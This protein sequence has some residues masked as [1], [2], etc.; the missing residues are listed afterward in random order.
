MSE[1]WSFP[2]RT[3]LA[4]ALV[5]V[6]ITPLVAWFGTIAVLRGPTKSRQTF[7]E[8]ETRQVIQEAHQQLQARRLE[9]D[10]PAFQAELK[11]LLD[12]AGFSVALFD[13]GGVLIHGSRALAMGGPKGSVYQ[14]TAHYGRRQ[15]TA[16]VYDAEEKVTGLYILAQTDSDPLMMVII[17][18]S[19]AGITIT[20]IF[21]VTR[22][23]RA[24]SQPVLALSQAATKVSQ[25]QLDFQTPTSGVLE[26]N[27]LSEAF[28]SMRD[29]LCAAI[30]QQAAMEQERRLMVSAIAHDL[31]TPLTSVRGY[32]EGIRDGIG[33]SPKR[34]DRYVGVALAKTASMERLIEGLF[35]YARTEYLVQP[36]QLERLDVAELLQQAVEGVRPQ[37]EAK[38]VSLVIQGSVERCPLM[39]DRMMLSRVV[40]NLLDNAIRHTPPGGS[41]TVAWR[42]EAQQLCFWIQD[43]GPGFGQADMDRLFE[44][45][46]RGDEARS[47][48]TGGAGLGLAIARRLVEA[49]GGTI[50][51]TSDGG[52]RF[53]I[54]LPTSPGNREG[55]AP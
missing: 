55:I 23:G 15:L 19:L 8:R 28:A 20:A 1:H 44:P 40:D 31:R 5:A 7:W 45:L 2:L 30:A 17:Y 27:Q 39:A 36:P 6:I 14:S 16:F 41:V 3:W 51:A 25:G 26:L 4:I 49:H 46:Y 33:R 35:T 38:G 48:H 50:A 34:L 43:T 32:L 42:G 21:V 52:A 53:T 54:S 13:A 37:A 29:G 18:L 24:V 47:S 11:T 12:R 9:W 10:Q 22:V